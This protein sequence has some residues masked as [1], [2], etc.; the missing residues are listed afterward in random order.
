MKKKL[1][2]I[3]GCILF[4]I[5]SV[6][7]VP[8]SSDNNSDKNTNSQSTTQEKKE[9]EEKKEYEKVSAKQLINDLKAN[10]LKAKETYN[11]KYIE[12]TG[13]LGNIDSDGKYISV[14]P[15]GEDFI[16]TGIQAY[17]KTDEQKKVIMEFSKGQKI[18]VKG[19]ITSVGEV[20]GYS[21]DI[22]EISATQAK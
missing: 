6:G 10:A 19:K 20:M 12:I 2:L 1:S 11:E 16:L 17:V 9:S 21:V 14:D 13:Q 15:V 3:L 4:V 18:T 5:L 7:S 22:D 8:S